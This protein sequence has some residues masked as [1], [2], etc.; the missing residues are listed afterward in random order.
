MKM[1]TLL[2]VSVALF[3]VGYESNS[4]KLVAQQST[5]RNSSD[6]PIFL[7][8]N[9]SLRMNLDRQY[10]IINAPSSQTNLE[11]KRCQSLTIDTFPSQ[12]K[13]MVRSQYQTIRS[14]FV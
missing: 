4:S 14:P 3:S 10:S 2:I 9:P 6:V 8:G 5:P 7:P 11:C 13:I 1:G 12:E